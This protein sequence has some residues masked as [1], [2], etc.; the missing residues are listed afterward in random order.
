MNE[1]KEFGCDRFLGLLK[2]PA[3]RLLHDNGRAPRGLD[4][5]PARLPDH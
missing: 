3:R 2:D 4:D 1:Q 5:G